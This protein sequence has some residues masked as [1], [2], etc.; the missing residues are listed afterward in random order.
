MTA[1][2]DKMY[3]REQLQDFPLL[4]LNCYLKFLRAEVA[5]FGYQRASE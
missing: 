2:L 5:W 1:G 3:N 4:S